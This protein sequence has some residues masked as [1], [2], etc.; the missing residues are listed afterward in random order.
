[1][2][3]NK[4]QESFPEREERVLEFWKSNRVFEQSVENRK[5]ERLFSSYDGPPFATGLP[6]YGHI[7]A[8]TLKDTVLR[9]KTMQGFYVPR[10]FGWDCHGLPV[11]NQIE[12]AK[13]LSGAS[14]I[15]KFGI[16]AFNEEC[17]SVVLCYTSEWEKTVERMGRWVSFENTYKTMDLSFMES[18]WWVFGQLYNQGLVYEGFKVM[19]FSAQLGTPLSNFE[20]NLNYKEVDDPS[21]TVLFSLKSDPKTH[22]LVWTTTP[23]TLPS[24]LAILAKKDITYVKVRVKEGNTVCILSEN[25]LSRYFKSEDLYEILETFQGDK[26]E[27]LEYEPLFPYFA[28]KGKTGAAFRVYLD[29]AVSNEDGTALLHAAPAFGEVDFF[30][31]TKEGIEIV[32]PVDSNGRFTAEVPELEGVYVKDADKEII[33][34]LKKQNKVFQHSQ[35]RH[36]Y[37]FCWRSDTPLIYKAVRTWFIAVEKIKDVM[38]RIND[39]IHWVP[40]HIQHGR[41]GKWLENARDWAISRNRYWGTPIPLWRSIE[42]DVRV[43]SS[44]EELEK[45]TGRKITDLHRHFIDDLEFEEGGKIF[46][47]IPEVFDCWFESGSMPYAQNH[48]PFENREATLSGFPADFIAEGLDQTRGWF[49]TLTVLAA[50]LFQKPA[51]KNVIVN[52]II[53]AEDGNKMSKRLKNYP[54]PD[55]VINKYGADAVRLYLLHSPAVYA[56]DLRFSERGVELVLRQVLIPF[57][58]SYIF[59]STYTDICDWKPKTIAKAPKQDIDRW[60][61]SLLQKLI[62]ETTRAMNSYHLSDAVGPI[63]EFIDQL[64]NWY[65]RRNR[66]RFWSDIA[67][68]DREEAFLTLYTV[69]VELSKITA[70]FIPFLSEAIYQKLRTIEDKTSVHLCDYPTV[71]SSYRDLELELEMAA[72]Q[73]VV[74]SGHALR[75]EHKIKVRQPLAKAHVVSSNSAILSSLKRQEH[76]I[77]EELNVK[78]VIYHEDESTFVAWVAKPNFRLLG[79]KVGKKM[80]AVHQIVNGFK[81]EQL[82]RLLSGQAVDI[83][84]EGEIISL[85]PE[86]IQ[87]ERKVLDGVVAHSLDQITV[88]LDTSL[89]P[90]LEEEG[91]A[92]EII[93]K[94]NLMRKEQGFSVTDRILVEIKTSVKVRQCIDLYKEYISKEVLALDFTFRSD[95]EGSV[96]DLNGEQATIILHV[97]S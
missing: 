40:D 19:P 49:Y 66:S 64:T 82:Q 44:I 63:T 25:C 43:F 61:L 5:N 42:G 68:Q 15:E 39:E 2:L 27:G 9:Y 24:N 75:K 77:A 26:L 81:Q 72:V 47:R 70:P 85:T 94:I 29:D 6:H 73:S 13:E 7:L 3:E 46:R 54:E 23:W 80:N 76:L 87:V 38:L 10:R 56:E 35:I 90:E 86:D 96:I 33:K 89:T 53:L 84:V 51:F 79:K 45:K 8:G 60:I 91:L 34:M 65:I 92:R 74:S 57:W 30:A 21:L 88:A 17:R 12:K 71:D 69:L 11:E 55:L 62:E 97:A 93:N 18:V 28:E 58:N 16:G 83:E 1:M 22:L 37:P 4:Q 67:S 36:R 52:G 31:C 48:F 20:A 78:Q 14:A 41:F 32:C 95:L 59:L 50:A